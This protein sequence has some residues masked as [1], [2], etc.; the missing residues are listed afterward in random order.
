[1]LCSLM[2]KGRKMIIENKC[3]QQAEAIISYLFG[4]R[5]CGSAARFSEMIKILR[6]TPR[7]V[8]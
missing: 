1:M 5:V 7:E 4:P 6:G 8:F 2:E 3:Q